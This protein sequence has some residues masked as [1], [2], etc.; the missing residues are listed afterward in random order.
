MFSFWRLTTHQEQ[1]D[2]SWRSFFL[3][4][5]KRSIAFYSPDDHTKSNIKF[6]IEGS[7]SQL[8]ALGEAGDLHPDHPCHVWSSSITCAFPIPDR[9]PPRIWIIFENR[10]L[11]GPGK[12]AL[13]IFCPRGTRRRQWHPTPVLLPGKSHGWRSLVGCS[14]W[15]R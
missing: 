8:H 6:S 10:D 15:G 11:S 9:L 5:I 4:E 13:L 1:T 12:V 14:P 3:R 2:L 7:L